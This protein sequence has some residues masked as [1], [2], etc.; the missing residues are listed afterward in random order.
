MK[1]TR[2]SLLG[3]CQN[4]RNSNLDFDLTRH[5]HSIIIRPVPFGQSLLRHVKPSKLRPPSKNPTWMAHLL[6]QS[7]L[8][9]MLS[10]PLT[11]SAAA[12]SNTRPSSAVGFKS[13]NLGSSSR[14]SP[15]VVM[16]PCTHTS[17]PRL[18]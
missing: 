11:A 8:P 4:I 12:F 10:F 5:Y 6:S 14:C 16:A 9:L 17:S 2:R 3:T 7:A 18:S 15:S 13:T 1:E